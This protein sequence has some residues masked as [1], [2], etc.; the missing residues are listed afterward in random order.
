MV[1]RGRLHTSSYSGDYDTVQELRQRPGVGGL[2]Q[3]RQEDAGGPRRDTTTFKEVL[4]AAQHQMI[5]PVAFL[6]PSCDT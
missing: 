1:L 6:P 5:P 4:E 2:E 3:G